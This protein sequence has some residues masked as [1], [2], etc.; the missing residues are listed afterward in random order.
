MLLV[1]LGRGTLLHKVDIGRAFRHIKIDPADYNLLGLYR[2]GFFIDTCLP[3]GYRH[4]SAH[5]QRLSDAIR[6]VM[7]KAGY[8]TNYIDDILGHT[9]SS[10]ANQSFQYLLTLLQELGLDINPK[11]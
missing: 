11:K 10:Q 7:Q 1:L 9:L 2:N 4:G 6:Y 5:F 3:F 8:V